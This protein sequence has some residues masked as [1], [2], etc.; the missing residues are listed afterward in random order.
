MRLTQTDI[1]AVAQYP[2]LLRLLS[3]RE[4][5]A[6]RFM[7]EYRDGELELLTGA[8]VWS[9]GWSDAIAIRNRDDAKAFRCDPAGGEVWGREGGLADVLDPLIELPAPYAPHAP[10][11]V[12]A[13][14][15][16]LW[17]PCP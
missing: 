14:A 6:W 16:R 15:P 1:A 4:Q 12:K 11:L 7:P 8:R 13:R 9:D 3:L 10:M 2:E 17:T 5:S